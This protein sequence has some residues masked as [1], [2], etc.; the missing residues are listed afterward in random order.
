MEKIKKEIKFRAFQDNEMLISPLSSNYGLARFF[1]LLYEDTPLMQYTGL[2]DADGKMV[3]EGDF[4]SYI[5]TSIFEVY[6]DKETG[7]FMAKNKFRAEYLFS[8]AGY[9]VIG[10]IYQNPELKTFSK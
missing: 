8:F 4:I 6:F 5:P 7:A 9:L 1:G 2:K 3:Y 10:N